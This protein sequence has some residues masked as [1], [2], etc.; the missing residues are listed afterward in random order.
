M[1]RRISVEILGDS[2]S[3]ERSFRRS[4]AAGN[5]F[6]RDLGR[7]GRGVVAVT[8]G[9]RSLARSVAF[10]SAAFV[11]TAGITA[12]L[13]SSVTGFARFQ[14]AMQRSVG[15]AGV[16]QKQI[17]GFSQ[18]ILAL[19][20]LVGKSPEE[21]A[22]AFYFVASSGIAVSKAMD[23]VTA[24]AKASAAG[25]GETQVVA[26]AVTSAI[27][28]YG[29]ANLSAQKA[30][31]IL[32]A[33]V[34][35]GKGEASSFA[36]VIGNVAA[37]AAQ[38][39][40]S[41]DQVGAALARQTQLGIDAETAATQLQRV[42]STLVKVTPQS[43]KAF[44]AVGLNADTL[45]AQ[46]GERDGLLKVLNEV[47]KAFAGR[48]PDLA[49][50]FGDVRAVRGVLALVGGDVRKTQ[51]VFD[52][53]RKSSGSLK[54]AF[55]AV[56]STTAQRFR[57]LRSSVQVLGIS[58][59]A[60]LAPLAGIVA[61]G[62]AG[63]AD[64]FTKFVD[65]IGKQQTI[66]GKLNVVWEGVQGA[67][68]GAGSALADA[69]S[70][71]DWKQVWAS[72][73]GIADGLQARLEQIDWGQIG[74][75]IGDGLAR[76]VKNA[77][78]AAK[79]F[80]NR[81][82]D[83]LSAIDWEQLGRKMGPGLAAA[84]V[85]AFA[86]LTDPAFWLRNWDLALAVG[87]TVFGGSIG[88]V[89]GK[90]A[91]PLGRVFG[92]LAEDAALRFAQPF[93]RI[94]TRLGQI[95]LSGLIGLP[96]Q[97]ARIMERLTRPVEA[98]F[99]RLG[100]VARFA[101][102]VVGFDIAIRAVAAFAQRVYGYVKEPLSIIARVSGVTAVINTIRGL[103]GKIR[104]S[105]ALMGDLIRGDIRGVFQDLER[106]A[107]RAALRIIEPFTHLP[108]FLGGGPFRRMKESLQGQ[109]DGMVTASQ[110]AALKI[111]AAFSTTGPTLEQ[112]RGGLPAGSVNRAAAF[113]GTG[114]DVNRATRRATQAAT[115]KATADA[116]GSATTAV[117]KGFELPF[118]LRLAEARAAATKQTKDDLAAARD[119]RGFILQ[120]IPRLHGEKLIGAYQAL[121]D[122][123]DKIASAVQAAADKAKSFTVPLALQVSQAR[124][125]ALGKP[126]VTILG[127][128]K[129][130]AQRAL[131]SHKL[132]LQGQL[133]AWNTIASINDQLKNAAKGAETAFKKANTA[134]LLEGFNLSPAERKALR[135]RL[136]QVGA[137]GT[138]P[139]GSQFALAGTGGG[140]FVVESKLI[141]D[142][143]Q[144]ASNTTKHQ[145]KTANRNPGQRRGP[146]A[147]Q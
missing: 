13:K 11:G 119:I 134:K 60:I 80:A 88:R 104:D 19:A 68:R 92:R 24:S 39:G 9:Y 93:E 63:A 41:F 105:F 142:G 32:V 95:V 78:P 109:L 54:T 3:L 18:Q 103:T 51:Q 98:T 72:A 21:L 145:Q 100:S 23:V 116:T 114:T 115:V 143:R 22:N 112:A 42:F 73:R 76:A 56:S 99:S 67:A 126:I 123:T 75:G 59:G 96:G 61:K 144:V 62:L 55:D 124:A 118:R 94:S 50:A 108:G 132:G 46:L 65:K 107:I 6:S 47:K 89:A 25:L 35:E 111:A 27:N 7:A 70:R 66:R 40:V 26:D 64:E 12:A 4:A 117:Q 48:L 33:T 101:V 141:L 14:E 30:S 82:T 77:I 58:I 83:A 130:A 28:A 120:A 121:G 97:V 37:I 81:I 49:K 43:A 15:L 140:T 5:A 135:A 129:K 57:Q 138:V 36:G 2:R 31:D 147:G 69:V 90:L 17:A 53:L 52:S 91:A 71:V 133:D 79:D 44:K 74:K 122:A 128:I 38:L 8:A 146:H 110:E 85:T 29:A 137:G 125:E 87:L 136:S 45:R 102:K 20:P 84:V 86:T 1:A 34:R 127:Q 106:L 139:R 113:A 131:K 10:A 16:A